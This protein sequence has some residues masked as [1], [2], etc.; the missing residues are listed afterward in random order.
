MKNIV[1]FKIKR[2]LIQVKAINSEKLEEVYYF[3]FE[4]FVANIGDLVELY[5]NTREFT[6]KK[7]MF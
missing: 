6:L 5:T 2:G 1:K 4:D 3:D 7:C